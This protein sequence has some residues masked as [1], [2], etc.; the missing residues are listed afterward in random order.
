ME[1]INKIQTKNKK[2][3]SDFVYVKSNIFQEN[4]TSNNSLLFGQGIKINNSPFI[5]QDEKD[6]KNYLSATQCIIKTPSNSQIFYFPRSF[7]YTS[8]YFEHLLFYLDRQSMLNVF[9][10][11]KDSCKKYLIDKTSQKESK[12]E[13]DFAEIQILLED[14]KKKDNLNYTYEILCYVLENKLNEKLEIK[15][16]KNINS[17]LQFNFE[18]DNI[19]YNC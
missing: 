8:F 3:Y 7:L 13:G 17:E 9:K 11:G 4:V 5:Y 14:T 10:F 18:I 16:S 19:S 12:I 1:A 6:K 15:V 2:I